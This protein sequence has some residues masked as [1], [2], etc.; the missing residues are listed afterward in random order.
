MASDQFA[1]EARRRRVHWTLWCEI[2]APPAHWVAANTRPFW[3]HY[4]LSCSRRSYCAHRQHRFC[5][6][7]LWYESELDRRSAAKAA[8]R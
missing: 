3:R 6:L 8:M 1:Q 2:A 5:G 7:K 4:L